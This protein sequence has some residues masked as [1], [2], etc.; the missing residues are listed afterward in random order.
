MAKIFIKDFAKITEEKAEILT[1]FYKPFDIKNGYKINGMVVTEEELLKIGRLVDDI[2]KADII[3]GKTP[4]L[5][6]NP[7]ANALFYEYVDDS[8]TGKEEL[9]QRIAS[10]EQSNAELTTLIATMT[11]PTV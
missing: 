2:G 10:L 5:Y 4:I 6:Y 11:A 9:E 1:A 3:E 7:T 8:K